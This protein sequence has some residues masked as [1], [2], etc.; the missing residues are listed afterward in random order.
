MIRRLLF[1]LPFAFGL[2]T[3]L[4]GET[5]SAQMP[6]PADA[7]TV[8]PWAWSIVVWG[9]LSIVAILSSALVT[10]AAR[11]TVAQLRR[12]DVIEKRLADSEQMQR[13]TRDEVRSLHKLADGIGLLHRR[14]DGIER[15]CLV[16][17]CDAG[18]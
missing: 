15:G 4:A 12:L 9:L 1:A 14:M 6:S 18:K 16:Q 7:E 2:L 3:L 10:L 5:A 11:Y 8:P 17:H 13:E